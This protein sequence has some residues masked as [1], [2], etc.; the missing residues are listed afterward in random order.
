MDIN[1]EKSLVRWEQAIEERKDLIRAITSIEGFELSDREIEY[2][3]F[4]E[5][6]LIWVEDDL[7]FFEI[8]NGNGYTPRGSMPL[9]IVDKYINNRCILGVAQDEYEEYRRSLDEDGTEPTDESVLVKAASL[10]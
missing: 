8:E 9:K 6:T 3:A 5:R 2:R 7:M 1:I 10:L 4:S